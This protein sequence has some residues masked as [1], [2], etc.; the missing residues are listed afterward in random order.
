MSLLG[1]KWEILNQDADMTVIAKLLKNRQIDSQEKADWFFKGTLALLHDPSL[2]MEMDKG[3][4][5]IVK[6]IEEKEKIMIFGDYDVDG[7]TATAI[8]YDFLKK[9]GADVHYTLPQREKDGYGLKDYFIERFSQQGILLIVTVDCG[10]SNVNEIALASEKGIDVVVTDHHGIPDTLPKACAII[11]P[12]QTE[13]AYPNKEICG[14]SIAYKLV[15]TL[16]KRLWPM[17]KAKQY[18]DEQLAIVALGVIGDC[19][20]LTG[21]NR[22]LVKEGLKQLSAGKNPGVVALLKEAN[23]PSDQ[24]TSTTIGYQIGPRINAAGRLDNPDHAFELLIG[25]LEKAR[26]LNDLNDRRRE[27]TK[28]YVDDAVARIEALGKLPN[29]IVLYSPDWQSGLLGL[30]ASGLTDRFTRPA[31]VMQERENEYVGSMRSVNQFD[32]TE[33][34]R[35]VTEGLF[36]SFG[37]HMMAGGFTLPKQNLQAFLDRVEEVGNTHINPDDFLGT[38]SVDC[39]ITPDELTLE[40]CKKIDLLEPFGSNNPEPL[41]VL[42]NV[43]IL[44]I[45]SVGKEGDHLQFP[46][47]CGNKTVTA[48]AFRFGKYLDKIDPS[49]PHD[50]VCN[51]QINEWNGKQKLQLK[52]VD[53]KPAV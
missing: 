16:A 36:A 49:L 19:M 51:V 4:D 9:A 20:A 31:I 7:I 29:I 10:T 26:V 47:R 11:N 22:I 17:E 2:L 30:I 35:A 46:V 25:N 14:S 41:L 8:L 23:L 27:I 3:A 28:Q 48:I 15:T 53:L 21:E 37:G 5:R 12:Q 32:I 52:V 44:D 43:T 42:K 38:L 13:C 1:K 33:N 18:L 45:K 40:T 34:L 6:A 24:I 39:A 50:I